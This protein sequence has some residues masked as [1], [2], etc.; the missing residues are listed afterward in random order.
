MS[1][2][3]GEGLA[4]AR[5]ASDSPR[6]IDGS[7]DMNESQWQECDDPRWMIEFLRG[8]AGPRKWRLFCVASC[9][10][11]VDS[12]PDLCRRT[13][14]L[15]ERYA[16][17]RADELE[18]IEALRAIMSHL[19]A[20]YHGGYYLPYFHEPA[21]TATAITVMEDSDV[22]CDSMTGRGIILGR[23]GEWR[24]REVCELV[25]YAAG[26]QELQR[27]H[28]S[29][30]PRIRRMWSAITSTLS[31]MADW[32]RS[33]EYTYRRSLRGEPRQ[34]A[35]VLREVFGPTPF[36]RIAITPSCIDSTVM[37]VANGIYHEGAFDRL[38]ILADALQDA[39]CENEELLAHFRADT[40]HVR[41]CWA[42]DLILS[43]C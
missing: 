43:K 1:I 3:L 32:F 13:L 16:D 30:E 17:N 35:K 26:L 40:A 11:I 37:A 42:L 18:R 22:L 21:T 24:S 28:S 39:G 34:Q 2:I 14:D 12:L 4:L 15:G 27:N 19:G 25:K 33:R 31:S 10:R 38:P 8:K 36:R 20:E 29:G 5:N 23:G 6:G 9:R 7:A 41:G